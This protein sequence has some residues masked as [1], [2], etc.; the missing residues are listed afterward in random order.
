MSTQITLNNESVTLNPLMAVGKTGNQLGTLIKIGDFA[1][2]KG[3]D[4]ENKEQKKLANR[5]Y[6]LAKKEFYRQAKQ[7]AALA[8]ADDAM[9]ATKAR[10]VFDKDGD[11][12]GVDVSHRMP[13]K[14]FARD[15]KG[16]ETAQ[17]EEKVKM[18]EAKLAAAGLA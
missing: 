15:L 13:S 11:L 8:V 9:L 16:A 6:T 3:Y 2:L 7:I 5:E 1:K 4:M 14:K 18:L 12:V 10:P 17:L